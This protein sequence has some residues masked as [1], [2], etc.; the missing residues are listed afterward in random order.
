LYLLT[1]NIKKSC[2]LFDSFLSFLWRYEKRKIDNMFLSMLDSQFKD[3]CLVSSFVNH[4]QGIWI[5]EKYD[6]KSLHPML[7]DC[8]HHLHLVINYEIGFGFVD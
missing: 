6:K 8:Y 7:L 1:S 5:V 4:K 2:N 3:L